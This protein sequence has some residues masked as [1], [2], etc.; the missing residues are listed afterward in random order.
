M[1]LKDS[2]SEQAFKY[3]VKTEYQALRAKGKPKDKAVK[4]AVAIGFSQKR[5][6]Q[7]GK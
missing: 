2:P 5:R 7:E 6:A 3:N 1:P 4:Q